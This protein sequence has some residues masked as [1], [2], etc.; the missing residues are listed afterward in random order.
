MSD[1]N[2]EH[3]IRWASI[4]VSLLEMHCMRAGRNENNPF[5]SIHFLNVYGKCALRIAVGVHVY[6]S[7]C[8]GRELT[9][10]CFFVLL[11]GTRMSMCERRAVSVSALLHDFHVLEKNDLMFREALNREKI[12]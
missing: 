6:V 12:R 8:V 3:M 7:V 1:I 10:A 9:A 11:D 2:F 5:F 4:F